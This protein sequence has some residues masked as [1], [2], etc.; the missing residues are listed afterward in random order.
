MQ[1]KFVVARPPAFAATECQKSTILAS[2]DGTLLTATYRHHAPTGHRIHLDLLSGCPLGLLTARWEGVA[3]YDRNAGTRSPD[4]AECLLGPTCFVVVQTDGS[5]YAF[6]VIMGT[7][8]SVVIATETGVRK[9]R[10]F[11]AVQL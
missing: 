1:I 7:L 10:Q 4:V 6:V 8:W 3:R 2:W 11:I 5:R 9:F